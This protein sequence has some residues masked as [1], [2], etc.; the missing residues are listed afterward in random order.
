MANPQKEN[1]YTAIANETMDNLCRLKL[2]DYESRV[3]HVIFR[4]TYGWDKK[5]DI[6]SLSQFS[7]LTGIL[8]QHVARTIKDLVNRNIIVANYL[9]PQSVEYSFQK[10]YDLWDKKSPLDLVLESQLLPHKVLPNEVLPIQVLPNEVLPIQDTGTTNLGSQVLPK[11]VDTITNIQNN[12]TIAINTITNDFVLPD[13]VDNIIW[14]AFVEMRKKI[15][16]P[17]TEHAKYLIIN[18]LVILKEK[19]YDP[20]KVLD[21]STMNG[22]KGVFEINSYGNNGHKKIRGV[23]DDEKQISEFVWESQRNNGQ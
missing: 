4:K 10:N 22:W 17:L 13:W 8:S 19:G 6:I 20:N 2:S 14:D 16:S 7:K 12:S 11:Q 15:K 9:T 5:S 21:Q 23:P 18:K 3:L 1:G